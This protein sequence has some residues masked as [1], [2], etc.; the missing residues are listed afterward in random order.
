MGTLLGKA[1]GAGR[2]DG[3]A[4]GDGEDHQG[5][6]GRVVVAEAVSGHRQ[7]HWAEGGGADDDRH[8]DPFDRP[9]VAS[10]EVTDQGQRAAVA[11]NPCV[12]A[13]Q[14]RVEDRPL[15]RSNHWLTIQV[16]MR[17]KAPWPSD[18]T[19]VRPR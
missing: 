16:P 10:A 1:R 17:V 5:D 2:P 8:G 9:E 7:R 11:L 12:Q 18:R 15:R 6:Q 3:D 13:E 4:R 19:Q 14:G